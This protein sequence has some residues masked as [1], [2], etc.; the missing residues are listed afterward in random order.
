MRCLVG[1]S[2]MGFTAATL[3]VIGGLAGT[4]QAQM[5]GGGGGMGGF[6]PTQIRD[7]MLQQFQQQ[8][9]ATDEEWRVIQPQFM[10]VLVAQMDSGQGML[11]MLRGATRGMG[12]RGGAAGGFD[13]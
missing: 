11:G 12:G 9:G 4:A 5:G 13:M 2:K 3:L 7:R 6:D 1:N 8:L 10:K